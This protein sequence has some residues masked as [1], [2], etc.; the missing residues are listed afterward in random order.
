MIFY[1]AAVKGAF[2]IEQQRAEDERGYFA[3]TWCLREFKARGLNYRLAQCSTSFNRKRGTLRG[4][5]YQVAPHGED[6]LVRCTRGKIYD[7]I[8]D[9][10]PDS[11]TYRQW[12]AVEL[13]QEHG[14]ILYVPAGCAHGLIT[15]NDNTEVFYQISE[16]QT[17][18][19][20]RGFRWNDPAFGI[21]WPIEINVISERDRTY[22]DFVV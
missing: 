12:T 16:F 17:P 18:A 2:I 11:P 10:R 1:E 20:A 19:A 22:Q 5:H 14:N 7:V 6:K 9:L 8:V 3:R 4:M 13:S 15:L 21:H